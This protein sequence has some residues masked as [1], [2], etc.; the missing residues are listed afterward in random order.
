MS[1][2]QTGDVVS[3]GIRTHYLRS[4]GDKP[5]LVLLHGATDS[6]RCWTPI[7]EALTDDY[8][9][10]LPDARGHGLSDAP[11][12]GYSSAERAA[13]TAGL[14]QALGLARV[15]V[16]GHS[17]GG[18]TTCRLAADY[19]D[20]VACAILE[21]PPFRPAQSADARLSSVRQSMREEVAHLKGLSPESGLEYGRQRHPNWPEAELPA[22]VESKVQ[23]SERFM[24]SP[25]DGEDLSWTSI[26]ARI[27]CPV[28]LVVGDA[29]LGA[30]ITLEVAEQACQLTPNLE[31]AHLAGAGHNIR[32][33]QSDAFVHAVRDFLARQRLPSDPSV[34]AAG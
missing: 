9:V 32:R 25:R 27:N 2:W 14:I 29:N 26:V 24:S 7:A 22:W 18:Q 21:D 17:M 6:G 33:E 13:D 11:H 8:D 34:T 28:L 20:L 12:S 16:G 10:V 1:T 5:P 19:P 4:G 30:I 23:L 15:A 31:V 3:N